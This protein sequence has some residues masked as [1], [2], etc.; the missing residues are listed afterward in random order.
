M[1]AQEHMMK[2]PV[3]FDGKVSKELWEMLYGK[4]LGLHTCGHSSKHLSPLKIWIGQMLD[5]IDSH[6]CENCWS[7]GGGKCTCKEER[8]EMTQKFLLQL[9][10]RMRNRNEPT[11][12]PH[13]EERP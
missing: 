9:P 11:L 6:G 8:A 13:E 10:N 5:D 3:C 2:C 7:D 4:N 12:Q 1:S